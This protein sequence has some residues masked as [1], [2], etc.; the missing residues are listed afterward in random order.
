MLNVSILVTK[1]FLRKSGYYYRVMNDYYSLLHLGY[2][3]KI[4]I[5]A[6]VIENSNDNINICF[7]SFN[8]IISI[9]NNINKS[10]LIICENYASAWVLFIAKSLSIINNVI[11][12]WIVVHG[13]L[14]EIENNFTGR[15]KKQVFIIFQ[16]HIFL[17][18]DQII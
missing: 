13:S 16:K 17:H 9:I 11:V 1:G 4:Y 14:D 3:P 18:N 6:K 12:S 8:N 15:I 7:I 5:I 10:K 2:Q